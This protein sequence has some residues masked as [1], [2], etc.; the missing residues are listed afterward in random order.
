MRLKKINDSLPLA[1]KPA[2]CTK[3]LSLNFTIPTDSLYP[4]LDDFVGGLNRINE[5]TSGDGV[6]G[7]VVATIK[8]FACQFS[9][10]PGALTVFSDKLFTYLNERKAA[11]PAASVGKLFNGINHYAKR[12]IDES[13]K[14][15]EKYLNDSNSDVP[16][17]LYHWNQGNIAIGFGVGFTIK[18]FPPA[19]I[20]FG[21]SFSCA[22]LDCWGCITG[23]NDLFG[24][25]RNTLQNSQGNTTS[26]IA[27]GFSA[28]ENAKCTKYI[29]TGGTWNDDVCA[30]ICSNQDEIWTPQYGCYNSQDYENGKSP[31]GA[32]P[33][34]NPNNPNY[35]PTV[36][37]YSPQY[38][39]K[40]DPNPYY[41]PF[42]LETHMDNSVY[43]FS[44]S[45]FLLI[46]SILF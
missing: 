34:A 3:S 10:V 19:D 18:I 42:R 28:K 43:L 44:V 25:K 37:P 26:W 45:L 22:T 41:N 16:C 14:F 13:S 38:D 9:T 12:F 29:C 40:K 8:D 32:N 24:K 15:E 21:A 11:T 46:L 5:I 6:I 33:S 7:K 39:P 23:L 35:D 30:C 4:F 1:T 36:D 20:T 27:D 31:D 2:F 17:Y